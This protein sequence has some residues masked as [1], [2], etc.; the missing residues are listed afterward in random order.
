MPISFAYSFMLTIN[1][2]DNHCFFFPEELQ[3]VY[4]HKSKK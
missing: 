4:K 1:E 3:I 2:T